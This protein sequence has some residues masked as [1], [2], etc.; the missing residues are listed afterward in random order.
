MKFYSFCIDILSFTIIAFS[1]IN[2]HFPRPELF[3][4]D[5]HFLSFKQTFFNWDDVIKSS[6]EHVDFAWKISLSFIA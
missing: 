3:D 5:L 6:F 1:D 2:L 4:G